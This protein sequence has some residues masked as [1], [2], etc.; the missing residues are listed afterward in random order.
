MIAFYPDFAQIAI[1][2]SDRL[3]YNICKFSKTEIAME[4]INIP[5]QLIGFVGTLII[6]LSY[7]CKAQ[8]KILL[9]Q[10]ASCA[11]F[12]LH[13]VIL[14]AWTGAALNFVGMLRCIVFSNRA[15]SRIFNNRIWLY[16]FC[17]VSVALGIATWSNWTSIMPTIAMVT[18][19]FALW[20]DSAQTNRL[21]SLISVSPLWMIY[22][23][24]NGSISGFV[25]EL[26]VQ[27]SI[28]IGLVR[29]HQRKGQ[30]ETVEKQ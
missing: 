9:L 12:T 6:V 13:F 16:G 14:G 23:L 8:R 4:E 18:S 26:I 29:Y 15:G 25:T 5:A 1:A 7:Q 17:I 22:N 19:S 10:I 27:T 24:L 30:T 28:I 20:S 3:V 11:V 21:I 2:K